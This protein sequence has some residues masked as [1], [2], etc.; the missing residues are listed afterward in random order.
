[1]A[2]RFRKVCLNQYRNRRERSQNFVFP[3]NAMQPVIPE[4]L[5]PLA[6]SEQWAYG[7]GVMATVAVANWSPFTH[8]FS[9][10][11]A[12]FTTDG[13]GHLLVNSSGGINDQTTGTLNTGANVNINLS[14]AWAV[15]IDVQQML[16]GWNVANS[17]AT[18]VRFTFND[19]INGTFNLEIDNSTQGNF[20][21]IN[22]I[23]GG[24]TLYTAKR[25][26]TANFVGLVTLIVNPTNFQVW[27]GSKRLVIL[28]SVTGASQLKPLQMFLAGVAHNGTTITLGTLNVYGSIT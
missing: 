24:V 9:G 12:D 21:T 10:T 8:T 6:W 28:N 2:K 1:M 19:T 15:Q 22:V 16:S 4:I 25:G 18:T 7:A 13:A 17:V 14:K 27:L 11:N 26:N 23:R 3:G 20:C 5:P